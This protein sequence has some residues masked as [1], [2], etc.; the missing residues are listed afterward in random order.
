MTALHLGQANKAKSLLE[1]C[2]EPLRYVS[3]VDH[4]PEHTQEEEAVPAI[5]FQ[6]WLLQKPLQVCQQNF[7][8]RL[9]LQVWTTSFFAASWLGYLAVNMHRSP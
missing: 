4:S 2:Q 8:K 6:P 5:A 3:I 9:R 1:L 7:Q